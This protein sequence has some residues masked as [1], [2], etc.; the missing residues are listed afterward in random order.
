MRHTPYSCHTRGNEASVLSPASPIT[1][2][3]IQAHSFSLFHLIC[4]TNKYKG[5]WW[6]ERRERMNGSDMQ[7]SRMVPRE[8]AGGKGRQGALLTTHLYLSP[9]TFLK[10]NDCDYLGERGEKMA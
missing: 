4:K 8:N 7:R 3:E 2:V 6:E 1:L 10:S 9:P 5:Y